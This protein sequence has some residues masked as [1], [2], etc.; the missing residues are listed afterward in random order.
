MQNAY[1][2][3]LQCVLQFP[4][5]ECF[6]LYGQQYQLLACSSMFAKGPC[7]ACDYS[8]HVQPTEYLKMTLVQELARGQKFRLYIAASN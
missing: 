1:M 4:A 7:T 2:Y 5:A 8:R 3:R 6:P